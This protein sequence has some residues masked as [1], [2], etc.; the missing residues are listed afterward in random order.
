M[1][2]TP[3]TYLGQL[4]YLQGLFQGAL[5]PLELLRHL[6]SFIRGSQLVINKTQQHKHNCKH[7]ARTL[8]F[9]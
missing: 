3:W 7:L 1:L 8:L 2:L 5:S 9:I 6:A 4:F